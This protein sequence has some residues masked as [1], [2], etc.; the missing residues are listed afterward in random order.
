M[1]STSDL[2]PVTDDGLNHERVL[3]M[4]NAVALLRFAPVDTWKTRHVSIIRPELKDKVCSFHIT[5][6]ATGLVST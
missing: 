5:S 4:T 6:T 3:E 2:D 1:I